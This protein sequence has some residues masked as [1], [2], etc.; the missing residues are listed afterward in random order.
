MVLK[1]KSKKKKKKKNPLLILELPPSIFN[2]PP[3]LFQISL[4]SSPFSPIFP[5]FLASLFPVG[6]QK[7][8]GQKCQEAL[9]HTIPPPRLLRHWGLVGC[10]GSGAD[11]CV[12]QVVEGIVS[13]CLWIHGYDTQIY[14]GPSIFIQILAS[15]ETPRFIRCGHDNY[16]CLSCYMKDRRVLDYITFYTK[17]VVDRC[18]RC[19]DV[20]IEVFLLDTNYDSSL[21]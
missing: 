13:L 5:F 18:L 15:K 2:F 10:D 11:V 6:Q 4:F 21:K 9:Y 7:F 1:S 19:K 8:P 12:C 3:S 20:W 17:T 14:Q 16:W